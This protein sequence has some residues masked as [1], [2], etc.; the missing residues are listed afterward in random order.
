MNKLVQ[1]D[2]SDSDEI[3][4]AVEYAGKIS[5]SPLT[6]ASS[7]ENDDGNSAGLKH[8]DRLESDSKQDSIHDSQR[9]EPSQA[10]ET[11]TVGDKSG[12]KHKPGRLTIESEAGTSI[13]MV[14][15]ATEDFFGLHDQGD[16]DSKGDGESE[17]W[18]KEQ[19]IHKHFPSQCKNKNRIEDF[20]LSAIPNSSFWNNPGTGDNWS[21]PVEVWGKTDN[22]SAPVTHFATEWG[23]SVECDTASRDFGYQSKAKQRRIEPRTDVIPKVEAKPVVKCPF[24]VH[25]KIT[26]YLHTSKAS[27][28]RLPHTKVTELSPGHAGIVNRIQ[29]N[30]AQFSHLLCSSSVDRTVKVWNVFSSLQNYCV[31]AFTFHEKA[32][33]D[34]TWAPSGKE[35]LSCS[36][37]KTA[38]LADVN[39]GKEIFKCE[40]SDFVTCIQFHPVNRNWFVSGSLNALYAWDCRNTSKFFRKYIYKEPFGQVRNFVQ[41]MYM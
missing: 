9:E 38:R 2:S 13:D 33:K 26:P 24:Y 14:S 17:I 6:G 21:N 4:D 20:Q 28:C 27:P 12:D 19:K 15:T 41:Y 23:T 3:D 30:V 37:D 5:P 35:I 36:Y 29:W 11:V 39:T 40:H 1:Y 22:S 25:H 34:V 7:G 31:Q 16:R 32:V 18:G 8:S 10:E